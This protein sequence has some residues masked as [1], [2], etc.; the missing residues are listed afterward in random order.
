MS[1]H[2]TQQFVIGGYAANP[3][4]EK[5]SLLLSERAISCYHNVSRNIL[6]CDAA[7]CNI[8]KQEPT[9]DIT[10]SDPSLK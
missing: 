5:D 9:R 6:F 8:T 1:H 10:I 3:N 7:L 2:L 4:H